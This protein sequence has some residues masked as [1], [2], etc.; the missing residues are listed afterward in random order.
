MLPCETCRQYLNIGS[1][2]KS[3]AVTAN[4]LKLKKQDKDKPNTEAITELSFHLKNLE[5]KINFDN[6]MMAHRNKSRNDIVKR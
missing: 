5:H 3:I 6:V 1:L 4:R 2:T